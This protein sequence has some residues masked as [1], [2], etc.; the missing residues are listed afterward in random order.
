MMANTTVISHDGTSALTLAESP[1][2]TIRILDFI[3]VFIPLL[4]AGVAIKLF[5]IE[6]NIRLIEIM[7]MVIGGFIIHSFLPS[8]WRLPGLFALTVGTIFW[9]LGLL[10]GVLLTGLG[11]LLF[12]LATLPISIKWRIILVAITG[13]VLIAMRIGW[14]PLHQ[15][16]L[17][18]PL[19]GTMFTFRMMVFLY[20]MQFEKSSA[21][22][23]KKLN[24]F[25]LLPNL[26]F[27]IFPVVDYTTFTRNY[28]SKPAYETYRRG[29]LMMAN[30]IM[31]LLLYRLIYYYLLPAPSE[32]ENIYNLLQFIIA[33]Y[34]LIVRLAGMFHFAAGVICLFGFYLPPT[35]DH[36]FFASSFTDI[37]RRINIY[38]RD[39][40]VKVF[41]FPIY[42]R[43]K[44]H[45]GLSML[46]LA[47]VIVFIINWLLHAF[48]WFWIRGQFPIT[49]QDVIFWN[50]FGIAVGINA[51]I[52]AKSKSKK[53][54]P[55]EFHLSYAMKIA[56]QVIGMFFTMAVLW[57]FWTSYSISEWLVMMAVSST[58]SLSQGIGILLSLM[59]LFATGVVVQY[60]QYKSTTQ[61]GRFN[62]SD[63]TKLVLGSL[64]LLGLNLF[65][66]PRIHEPIAVK[67]ELDIS[68]ILSTKLNTYD[69]EQQYKGYYE[70]LL[71]GNNLNSRLWELEVEKK[72]DDWQ[73]FSSLGVAKRRDDIMLKELL[74]NQI[75]PFKGA[76]FTT[77]SLG[78]RDR[79]YTFEKPSNTLRIALIGGSIEMG[80]G[81]NTDETYE[82]LIENAL[83]EQAILG[84]GIKVEIMNFAISNN[85][86]FQNIKMFEE[87]A[88][89]F[90]PDI[91]IYTA[92][93]NEAF[94]VL[95]S[96]FKANQNGRDLTYTYLKD[97][98]KKGDFN[99]QT[100]E[101]EF[102]LVMKDKDIE[103]SMWGYEYLRDTVER[104]QA[105]LLWL[106]VPTLDD[107]EIPGEAEE[108]QA[109]LKAKGIMTLLIKDAY[110]NQNTDVLKIA[111][112]DSHPNKEG[113]R[114]LAR[115]FMQKLKEDTTIIKA[116]KKEVDT[117]YK[118]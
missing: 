68:P 45:A 79:E 71:V 115:T 48:Q 76:L 42:F 65:G 88:S 63:N 75:K 25:F 19:L 95:Y 97:I 49:W 72:P 87:K 60:I 17:I 84:D 55:G 11:G 7:P 1:N 73:Q 85:H 112:W 34:A 26:V 67:L 9:L 46:F 113:H 54:A 80:V 5:H 30:G 69:R 107:N 13:V 102:M 4:M 98:I 111:K 82:N 106:Y 56:L 92:H 99:L 86:L 77:N 16:N 12:L 78:F 58:I 93:S 10:D 118:G 110:E 90:K 35:F 3:K 108:L 89:A 53:P 57:S 81:V 40:V 114:L 38:W 37:W 47:T 22:F 6:E 28:Y 62:L 59:G 27:V 96:V 18:L 31:H 117:P 109:L 70:T 74:P 91:V 83:N 105:K 29:L 101:S 50:L 21:G 61:N 104:S 14:L 20:E 39:F 44:K 23:W 24:Y 94:R 41:Y 36:Y 52:Q 116:L 64:F 15:S 2:T 51:I 100:T 32:I 43:L 8:A 66:M 33:S 103:L